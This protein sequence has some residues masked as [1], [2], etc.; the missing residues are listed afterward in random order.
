MYLKN[1][2][3]GKSIIDKEN[4]NNWKIIIKLISHLFI[5]ST[6]LIIKRIS[7]AIATILSCLR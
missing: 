1:V 2:L 7:I 3:Y 6:H 5:I 4:N